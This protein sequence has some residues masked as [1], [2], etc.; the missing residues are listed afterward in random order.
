MIFVETSIIYTSYSAEFE[1]QL[2]TKIPY[3]YI[4]TQM[5]NPTNIQTI[6]SST[7]QNTDVLL[8]KQ[9][10]HTVLGT[11]LTDLA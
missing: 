2:Y 10:I 3:N 5:P 4:W 1:E 8:W 6:L 7:P 11:G 9:Y